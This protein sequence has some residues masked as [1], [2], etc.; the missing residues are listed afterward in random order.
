MPGLG[1]CWNTAI[2]APAVPFLN[3]N[4]LG[5]DGGLGWNVMK[6]KPPCLSTKRDTPALGNTRDVEMDGPPL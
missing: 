3:F 1:A 5:Q 6:A 2:G 4:L